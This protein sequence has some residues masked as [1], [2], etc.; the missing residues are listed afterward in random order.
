MWITFCDRHS[1]KKYP[2]LNPVP[3]KT[4]KNPPG[5]AFWKSCFLK[6]QYHCTQ[7][8]LK[9]GLTAALKLVLRAALIPAIRSKMAPSNKPLHDSTT[10]SLEPDRTLQCVSICD[11]ESSRRL[12]PIKHHKKRYVCGLILSCKYYTENQC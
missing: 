8:V 12:L 4:Q 11:I 6:S 2:E 7:T 5:W 1:Y 3:N 10:I 9:L